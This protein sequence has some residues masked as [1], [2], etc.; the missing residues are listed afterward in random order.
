MLALVGGQDGWETTFGG[1]ACDY[2]CVC[3]VNGD[4]AVNSFDIDPFVACIVA[5]GCGAD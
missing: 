2:F 3:D 5:A 1:T 4:A